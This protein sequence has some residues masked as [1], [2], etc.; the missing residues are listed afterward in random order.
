MILYRIYSYHVHKKR[1]KKRVRHAV[2]DEQQ[3]FF[4]P[5]KE[6]L[7][8]KK[9]VELW[10]SP[11]IAVPFTTGIFKPSVWLPEDADA[12]SGD[13]L[14]SVVYHE[15][16]H[17]RHRD[18]F[19]YAIGMLVVAVHWF[20]PFSYLFFYCFRV[21]S[22]Q[23]SDET[24]AAQLTEKEKIRYCEMLIRISEGMK[25]TFYTGTGFSAKSK[26]HIRRRMDLIMKRTKK[27]IWIAVMA[28]IIGGAM[29][30]TAAAR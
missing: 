6:Q 18:L 12:Y 16:A 29:G 11:E 4:K 9:N 22:E 14:K 24:A 7:S 1:M 23:Y 19:L 28:G 13:E 15:L 25:K 20:N 17:I 26:K 30:M 27:R 21:I 5:A 3:I 10:Q 2:T 8:V